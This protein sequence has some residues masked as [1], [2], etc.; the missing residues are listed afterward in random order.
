MLSLA[1]VFLTEV[2]LNL[3]TSLKEVSSSLQMEGTLRFLRL[4]TKGI[5]ASLL[6]SMMTE[7]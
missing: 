1:E 3:L 6:L 7:E 2:T 4:V 5:F